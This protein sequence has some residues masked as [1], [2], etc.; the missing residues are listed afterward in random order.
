MNL[1]ALQLFCALAGV[2]AYLAL[3]V[4]VVVAWA[5]KLSSRWMVLA[6]VA[7]LLFLS[8]RLLTGLSA[9]ALS[10]ETVATLAW[11]GLLAH[12]LRIGR[13]AFR[14]ARS[15]NVAAVTAIGLLCGLASLATILLLAGSDDPARSPLLA[16][17]P[18]F[19]LLLA[20]C[21]LVLLEQV[22]RNTREEERWRTRYLSIGLGTLFSFQVLYNSASVLF[23]AHLPELLVVQPAILALTAPFIG[24]AVKRT[25]DSPLP[26]NISRELVFRTGVLLVTGAFLIGISALGY[27]VQLF[28]GAWDFAILTL[29]VAAAIMSL[30][31]V[32]G[33]TRV[34]TRGLRFLAEHVFRHKYDYRDQW[35]KV[36]QRLTEPSPDYDLAQQV[37]RA[38]GSVTHSEGGAV[39]AL[40]DDGLLTPVSQ[41]RTGW[42]TPLSPQTTEALIDWFAQSEDA[43]DVRTPPKELGSAVIQ[44]LRSFPDLRFAVP[45]L[46]DTRLSGIAALLN[47]QA[48]LR[49]SWE[50]LDILRLIAREA[51]G[52]VALQRAERSLADAGKLTSFNQISAFIVHD[53]K[54]I[55][56]QLS[57][58]LRNA[59]KHKTNPAF[60]DDMLKTV[61]NSVQR[62]NRLLEQLRTQAGSE[63]EL[64]DLAELVP[65]VLE[66]YALQQPAPRFIGNGRDLMVRGSAPQLGSAIGHVVQ[67]AIEA[68]ATHATPER[69]PSVEVRL[70]H[71]ERWGE[72]HVEDNGPG[73][74][75]NFL[76]TQLF[77]PFSSTKGV[78]GMGI[79]AYQ[80]RTYLRALGGDITVTSAPGQ[81]AHFVIRLPLQKTANP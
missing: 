38:L 2:A 48:A 39:W 81:G 59:E 31:V 67:N 29:F 41:L 63:T 5:R 6:C 46:T 10:L 11:I 78:S 22:S 64:L 72:I 52:F 75:E 54:T 32:F 4:Y 35:Q 18:I 47:P 40:S 71:N 14:E 55:S 23:Q 43:I 30:A 12:T 19:D 17:R 8:A 27:L 51:A 53:A 9:M 76:R 77:Q 60:I 69:S 61:D 26:V 73:M 13:H 15:R 44:E 7:T 65:R 45:L 57:L 25:A 34:R 56:A 24:I 20:V 80:A 36:T 68:A 58:L 49:L 62:I 28:G 21:C 37:V 33:S 74:D 50:D 42:D 66:P 16:L 79:G 3:T 70:S 1:A